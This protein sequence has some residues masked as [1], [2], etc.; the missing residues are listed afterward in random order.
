[1]LRDSVTRALLT[2]TLTGQ[3]SL[4]RTHIAGSVQARHRFRRTGPDFGLCF[5]RLTL[6]TRRRTWIGCLDYSAAA[7]GNNQQKNQLFM[8]KLPG[9]LISSLGKGNP[10]D[11]KGASTSIHA[12]FAA[13]G[14]I[15]PS[16]LLGYFLAHLNRI[17]GAVLL[18]YRLFACH[19]GRR[20]FRFGATA[21]ETEAD[22]SRAE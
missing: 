14:T 11:A 7:K 10:L 21:R 6:R 9:R 12:P 2:P 1:M 19:W 15:R 16:A 13:L 20:R 5:F 17:N 22:Q 18:P 8:I 4:L 3:I